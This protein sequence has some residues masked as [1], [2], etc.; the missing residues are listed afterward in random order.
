[1]W[2][3]WGRLGRP[4]KEARVSNRE[5]PPLA[6]FPLKGL[7]FYDR[8]TESEVHAHRCGRAVARAQTAY[9]DVVFHQFAHLGRGLI[10][11]GQFQSAESHG[12]TTHER[13]VHPAL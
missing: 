10:A 13:L 11:D 8:Y 3:D 12:H 6:E 9:Q 1:M 7:W 5:G 4:S 2:V